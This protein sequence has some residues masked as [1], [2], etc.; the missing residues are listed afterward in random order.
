MCLEEGPYSLEWWTRTASA[1]LALEEGPHGR[2]SYAWLADVT[3]RM[4]KRIREGAYAPGWLDLYL[5]RAKQLGLEE[6]GIVDHL[7]RF[8]EAPGYYRLHMQL[9]DDEIGRLQRAWLDRVR[10]SPWA[11]R[12]LYRAGEAEV[13]ARGGPAKAWH[14]GGL[15]SGRRTVAAKS[16]QASSLGFCHRFGSLCRRMGIDNPETRHIFARHDLEALYDRHFSRSGTG[17]PLAT[18]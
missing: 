10:W 13:G 16:A 5:R 18:F 12:P 15:F 2:H 17:D 8:V 6:V 9:G 3:R 14:R 11:F 7:Y 1:M 4:E